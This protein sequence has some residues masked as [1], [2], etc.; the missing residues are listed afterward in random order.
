VSSY[1]SSSWFSCESDIVWLAALAANFAALRA[2]SRVRN[3]CE[4]APFVSY[5]HPSSRLT[6]LK[7]TLFIYFISIDGM[8][9][10]SCKLLTGPDF[11]KPSIL[12]RNKISFLPS[13]IGFSSGRVVKS[14][15]PLLT[16][17]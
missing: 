1:H 17:D 16:E 9:D 5:T 12:S 11:R 13:V 10:F 7:V 15:D 2:A 14:A 4:S 6:I 3:L 8:N